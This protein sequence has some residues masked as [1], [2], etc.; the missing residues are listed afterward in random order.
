MNRE[1]RIRQL[2]TCSLLVGIYKFDP[3]TGRHTFATNQYTPL[4]FCGK[5]GKDKQLGCNHYD[6]GLLTR[7]YTA[8]LQ[9]WLTRHQNVRVVEVTR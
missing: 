5:C 6:D 3:T 7:V 4:S 8:N 9:E 1:Q 2:Q